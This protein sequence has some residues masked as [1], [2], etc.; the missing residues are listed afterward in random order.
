MSDEGPIES[1]EEKMALGLRLIRCVWHLLCPVIFLG[2]FLLFG[3]KGDITIPF[4]ASSFITII[5]YWLV[6]EYLKAK[7]NKFYKLF[8][9]NPPEL[10]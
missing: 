6:D 10:P 8:G 5:L 4:F 1:M 3:S 2:L 7:I 9:K